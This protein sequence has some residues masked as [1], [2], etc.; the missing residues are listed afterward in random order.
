MRSE[1]LLVAIIVLVIFSLVLTILIICIP[2][3]CPKSLISDKIWRRYN[4]GIELL[5]AVRYQL[6]LLQ[7]LQNSAQEITSPERTERSCQ[8]NIYIEP[9]KKQVHFKSEVVET[10]PLLLNTRS[11]PLL[12]E[13]FYE[14]PL[15]PFPSAPYWEPE[16]DL[17]E[18]KKEETDEAGKEIVEPEDSVTRTVT[19]RRLTHL[20]EELEA[21]AE[22]VIH[23]LSKIENRLKRNNL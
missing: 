8:A 4:R 5:R 6:L 2:T 11:L 10:K 7:N 9:S 19:I 14:L 22:I 17:K 23:R 18:E 16:E 1:G 20:E 15:P 12:T 21:T 13:D 3:C